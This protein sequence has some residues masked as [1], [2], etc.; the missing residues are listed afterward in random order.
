[1]AGPA[2]SQ[3]FAIVEENMEEIVI[4]FEGQ[5]RDLNELVFDLFEAG[6]LREGLE[7]ETPGDAKLVMKPMELKKGAGMHAVMEVGLWVGKN[8]AVP[9]FV[10]W[11]CNKWLSNG[12]KSISIKIDNHF[13]QFDEAVL[14][15]AIGETLRKK[16][17][18]TT[19][20]KSRSSSS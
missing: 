3:N 16:A 6:L 7:K 15:K 20:S 17:V 13:Y 4:G 2:A 12:Q 11:L 9:M 14:A 10:T 18:M 1:L 8:V 19:S 5:T